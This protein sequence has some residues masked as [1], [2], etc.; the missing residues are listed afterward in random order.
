[1]RGKWEKLKRGKKGFTHRGKREKEIKRTEKR[2]ERKRKKRGWRKEWVTR[3]REKEGKERKE[4]QK[5]TEREW[6]RSPWAP[7]RARVSL[8]YLHQCSQAGVGLEG[9]TQG[10]RSIRTNVVAIKTIARAVEGKGA[11]MESEFEMREERQEGGR[12]VRWG[13][14]W[15]SEGDE[16]RKRRKKQKSI[17]L[18]RQNEMHRETDEEWGERT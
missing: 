14:I 18:N 5:R 13:E 6:K 16:Q 9:L 3:S 8:L 11:L 15:E 1:M 10:T 12:K 4:R 17:D 7:H 2:V